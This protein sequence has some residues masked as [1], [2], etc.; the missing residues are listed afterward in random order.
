MAYIV[1]IPY[2]PSVSKPTLTAARAYAIR[3]L[4]NH[5]KDEYLEISANG[6]RGKVKIYRT[7]DGRVAAFEWVP[8]VCDL[9]KNGTIKRGY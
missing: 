6:G 2:Q 3:Y 8:P 9:N 7:I 5:P 1:H 4:T